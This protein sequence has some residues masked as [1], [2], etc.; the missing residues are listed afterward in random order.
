MGVPQGQPS[1]TL[2]IGASVLL[3][4]AVIA[5]L[6]AFRPPAPPPMPP[7]YRVNLVAAPAGPRAVGV[8][9]TTPAPAPTVEQ[10]KPALPPRSKVVA[11]A[12]PA[13]PSR[14]REKAARAKR[15]A[16]PV[17]PETKTTP[18]TKKT[19]AAGGGA[20]GGKGA[21]VANVS[22]AGIDFPFPGYLQ[23]ILRQIALRFSPGN[24][25]AL[26][27]EVAF[28]IHRDGSVTNFRFQKRSG[29]F[30]FD[31]AAQGA[32][33]AAGTGRA[34]GPLPSAYPDDVLPV[35]FSF[36]PRIIH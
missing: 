28:L 30:A 6:F 21:D 10:P 9:Q 20:E 7:V 2:P 31:L 17:P 29:S 13:P 8:V 3:H 33:D 24:S 18:M 25:G 32:V 16:T 35:I 15:D 26:T 1:L 23:N 27:A 11:K 19:Q 12:M 22:T 34:F 4:G 14:K 36:D 5:A